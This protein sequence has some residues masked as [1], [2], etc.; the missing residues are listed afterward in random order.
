MILLRS[1]GIGA[2]INVFTSGNFSIN[3][4]FL[5][6]DYYSI[7]NAPLRKWFEQIDKCLWDRI[8][9]EWADDMEH[10]KV[11]IPF[12]VWFPTF[13]S[14][15]GLP[16]FYKLPSI[17]VQKSLPKTWHLID[18]S[19]L[20]SIN[21]PKTQPIKLDVRSESLIASPFEKTR[22]GNDIEPARLDDIKKIH[23]QAN[24]TNTILNTIA[25]Q[26]DHVSTKIDS[27][28]KAIKIPKHQ[29]S[30]DNT[31]SKSFFKTDSIPKRN[32]EPYLKATSSVNSQL[33]T[34]IYE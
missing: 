4:P 33:L 9:K 26:L 29:P 25:R 21:P 17:N 6:Q 11:G 2:G 34:V 10:L 16:N 3:W 32:E 5:K 13:T 28:H 7:H 1:S 27:T 24:Y 14:R 31:I 12:Y 19:S 8:K 15:Y 18:G 23:Q 20:S 22:E 30:Y